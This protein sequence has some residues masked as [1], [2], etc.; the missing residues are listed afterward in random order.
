MGWSSA[1]WGALL[2]IW[3]I[4]EWEENTEREEEPTNLGHG[5]GKKLTESGTNRA[6]NEVKLSCL[7]SFSPKQ[8]LAS[9]LRRLTMMRC[10]VC[11]DQ[12]L[13][14]KGHQLSGLGFPTQ[15]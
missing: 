1:P 4:L 12:L 2:E 10:G 3:Q 14:A 9:R 7:P 11:E 5:L 6:L 13:R 15:G 8:M